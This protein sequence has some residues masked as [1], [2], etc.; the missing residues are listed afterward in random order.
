M[1]ANRLAKQ[2]AY[3]IARKEYYYHRHIEAVEQR[4]AREEALATGAHFGKGTLEIS[5]AL[6]DAQFEDWKEWALKQVEVE[7]QKAGAAYSGN[8]EEE[9]RVEES[10]G[11]LEEEP[12]EGEEVAPPALGQESE[13]RGTVGVPP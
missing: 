12:V 7:R 11:L 13:K 3:D 5:M 8:I 9:T 4:T 10:P 1:K 2:Q 6:E